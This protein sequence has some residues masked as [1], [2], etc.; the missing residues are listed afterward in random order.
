MLSEPESRLLRSNW[1]ATTTLNTRMKNIPNSK[2]LGM[3]RIFGEKEAMMERVVMVRMITNGMS[4]KEIQDEAAKHPT[5]QRWVTQEERQEAFDNWET[6]DDHGMLI[7]G[8]AKDQNGNEYYM[9][10]NSWGD[11]NVYHG[12]F[13]A[14]KAFVRYKTMNIVVHKVKCWRQKQKMLKTLWYMKR[15]TLSSNHT[16]K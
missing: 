7:Y 15:L 2:V 16:N 11:Y 13:Y 3:F 12:M 1:E 5:P 8:K 4:A 6:T 9:V 10:K 14:S